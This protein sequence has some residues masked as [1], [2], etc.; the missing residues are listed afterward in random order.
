MPLVEQ[1]LLTLPEDDKQDK[2]PFQEVGRSA[3]YRT[4]K[5]VRVQIEFRQAN[6]KMSA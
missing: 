4:I 6:K 1:I 2:N 5:Q 3:V